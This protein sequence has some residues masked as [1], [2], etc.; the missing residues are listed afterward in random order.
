[1][2]KPFSLLQHLTNLEFNGIFVMKRKVTGKKIVHFAIVL[3]F[4]ALVG[5]GWK[6]T[7]RS[8]YE[9]AVYSVVESDGCYKVR[10]SLDL[11][12]VTTPMSSPGRGTQ[13]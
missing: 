11:V 5:A 1:M 13:A 6:L 7:A 3:G 12:L 8:S 10:K 4:A 2:Y 9:S